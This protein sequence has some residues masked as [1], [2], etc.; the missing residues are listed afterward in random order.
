[1]RIDL[2]TYKNGKLDGK[3]TSYITTEKLGDLQFKN[4]IC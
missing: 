1:M 4:K 2:D 3:S